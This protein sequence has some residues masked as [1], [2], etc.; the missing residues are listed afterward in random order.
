MKK[1]RQPF[2]DVSGGSKNLTSVLY[3][4]AEVVAMICCEA[5]KVKGIMLLVLKGTTVF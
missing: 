4:N 5:S 2:I 1:V 3:V